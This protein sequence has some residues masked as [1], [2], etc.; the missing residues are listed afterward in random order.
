MDWPHLD[1]SEDWPHPATW[2]ES[3]GRVGPQRKLRHSCEQKG[4]RFWGSN[5][6]LGKAFAKIFHD[7]VCLKGRKKRREK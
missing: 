7:I 5:R 6:Y 4:D 3:K 1:R 2:V